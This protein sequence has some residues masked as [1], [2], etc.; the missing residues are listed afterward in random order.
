MAELRATPHCA[1]GQSNRFKEAVCVETERIFDSCSDKDCLEDLQVFFSRHGQSVIDNSTLIKC[2]SS[3]VLDTYLSVDAVPFNKG[4]FAVD[5]TFYC[6]MHFNCYTSLAATPVNV[7]G[8][9]YYTKKVILYGGEGGVKTFYSNG[10]AFED[11][12]VPVACLK[13]V[14]PIVLGSRV[15]D[16]VPVSNEPFSQIPVSV[17][18]AFEDEIVTQPDGSSKTVL[19][20]LGVFTIVTLQRSVQLMIPAYD[21][22]L[23]EKDCEAPLTHDEPCEIFKRIRFPV[24]EFF[25]DDLNE[26]ACENYNNN[27]GKKR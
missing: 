25:P 9:V 12:T 19:V 8:L 20:T 6:R 1:A 13:A 16:S 17:V 5:M 11:S 23:P 26:A 10:H 14:D 24:N 7:R 18:N 22:V 15:V 3:E 2:R 4:Y 21:Y 27:S